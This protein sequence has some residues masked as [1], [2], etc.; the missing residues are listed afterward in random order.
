M[1]TTQVNFRIPV[2]LKE[3]VQKKAAKMQLN[4]SEVIV[5]FLEKFATDNVLKVEV[6]KNVD[7]DKIFDAG[8]K[9]CLMSK[10]SLKKINEINNLLE[11]V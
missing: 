10:K 6:K 11:S 2:E 8:T 1:A 4:L 7:W 9:Q 3:K 5:I